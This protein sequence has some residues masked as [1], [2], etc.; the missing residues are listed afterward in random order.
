MKYSTTTCCVAAFLHPP[1]KPLSFLSQYSKE[2]SRKNGQPKEK[3]DLTA[4]RIQ[5][6]LAAREAGG[7]KFCTLKLKK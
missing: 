1:S 6:Q 4:H 5:K 7:V 2:A 3:G